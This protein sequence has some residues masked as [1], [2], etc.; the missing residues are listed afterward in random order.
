MI[1]GA[2]P[3]APLTVTPSAVTDAADADPEAAGEPEPAAE[4]DAAGAGDERDALAPGDDPEGPAAALTAALL[5]AE[6]S[7]PEPQALRLAMASAPRAAATARVTL[8]SCM[9]HRVVSGYML[10]ISRVTRS[11]VA[12]N[13]SLHRTVRWD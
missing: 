2:E 5:L 1:C 3:A 9:A 4:D 6:A 8:E 11:S 12:R 13:G 7:A 10:S